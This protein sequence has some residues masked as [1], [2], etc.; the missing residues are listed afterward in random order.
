[1]SD[2]RKPVRDM[3]TILVR[4]PDG[5]KER[6]AQR[7]RANGR[8]M[9]AEASLILERS[10]TNP[11]SYD[12]GALVSEATNVVDALVRARDS[13]KSYESRLDIIKEELRTIFGD[14]LGDGDPILHAVD[15]LR[16]GKLDL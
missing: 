13:A 3:D 8:S 1:M 4:L 16:Q 5:V 15:L 10:V 9:G 14:E 2:S 11:T 7:A 6:I 12:V